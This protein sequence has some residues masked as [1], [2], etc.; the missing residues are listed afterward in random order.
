MIKGI[1]N[2]TYLGI[3]FTMLNP[4]S[5]YSSGCVVIKISHNRFFLKRNNPG[6][7]S[8]QGKLKKR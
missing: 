1:M 6:L 2:C 7:V 3:V 5:F 8:V 4:W